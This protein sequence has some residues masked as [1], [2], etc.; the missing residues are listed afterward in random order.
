MGALGLIRSSVW[1]MRKTGENC[2]M[3]TILRKI[4]QGVQM[5]CRGPAKSPQAGCVD[6]EFAEMAERADCLVA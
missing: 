2:Q 5:A 1:E 4:P 6:D 3:D